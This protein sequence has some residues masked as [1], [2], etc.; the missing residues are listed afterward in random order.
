VNEVG[1]LCFVRQRP[2]GWVCQKFCERD[3]I[4]NIKAKVASM[5]K[6]DAWHEPPK[7]T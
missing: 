3:V 5:K 6:D 4:Q 1:E 2:V 7:G